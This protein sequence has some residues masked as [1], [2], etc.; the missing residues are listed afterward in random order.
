MKFTLICDESGITDRHMV[1]GALTLPRKNHPMLTGGFQDVKRKLKFRPE[2][3]IK[4]RS[5]D[6]TKETTSKKESL[7]HLT[8]CG[9]PLSGRCT[10]RY[11][12]R[13]G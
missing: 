12:I 4:C 1:V 7:T 9:V 11:R 2:G 13:C 3:E 5:S 10:I 6:G 8:P